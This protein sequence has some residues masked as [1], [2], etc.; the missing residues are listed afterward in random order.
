M[1]SQSYKAIL[2][3]FGSSDKKVFQQREGHT[4]KRG[5][6]C[7]PMDPFFW[8]GLPTVL[9]RSVNKT[10]IFCQVASSIGVWSWWIL[11]SGNLKTSPEPSKIWCDYI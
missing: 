2:P 4:V 5:F 1:K 10:D 9:Y 8:G 3:I 11:R 7:F 6:H